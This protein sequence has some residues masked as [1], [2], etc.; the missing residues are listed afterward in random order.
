MQPNGPLSEWQ[1]PPFRATIVGSELIARGASDDKGQFFIHLK[2]VESWLQP[3]AACRS[4]S[5]S[6]WKARTLAAR[7]STRYST[8]TRRLRADAALVSDTTLSAAGR[9]S[10]IYGL[11]GLVVVELEVRGASRVHHG[12]YGGAAHPWKR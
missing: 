4:T 3:P 5:R 11:R 7:T 8:A 1:T 9:P 12:R 10:I 6:G 2:A